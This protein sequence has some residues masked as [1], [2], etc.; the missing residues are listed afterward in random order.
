MIQI[1]L[2]GYQLLDKTVGSCN[3]H[4]ARVYVPLS[5]KGKK[6]TVVLLEPINETDK[7]TD[8]RDHQEETDRDNFGIF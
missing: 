7:P 5:W 3:N 2:Q 4:S 6:V 1:D 8:K